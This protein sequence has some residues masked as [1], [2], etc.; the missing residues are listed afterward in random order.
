M[1]EDSLKNY[2][3]IQVD[4]LHSFFFFFLFRVAPA[5]ME[6]PRLG[7][8]TGA[9]GAGL[10]HSHSNGASELHLQPTPQLTAMLDG[11]LTHWAGPGIEPSS[12]WIPVGFVTCWATVGTPR[13]L[14]FLTIKKKICGFPL[15]HSGSG[16]VIAVACVTAVVWVLSLAWECLHAAGVARK[17]LQG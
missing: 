8:W 7:C 9:A 14:T 13:T 2:I 5:A 1:A 17:K 10:H 6:V 16:A 11:S 3:Y 15:W 12:S 4:L